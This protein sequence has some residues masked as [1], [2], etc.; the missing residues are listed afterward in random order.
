MSDLL[1]YYNDLILM[2]APGTIFI[3]EGDNDIAVDKRPSEI[4]QT[5]RELT[6][7]IM[8]DLPGARVIF[9]SPKPSIARCDL[10]PMYRRLNRRLAR[11]CESQPNL[12]F[13]DV[14]EV[15]LDKDGVV[16]QDIFLEDGLHMNNKG[17]DLWAAILRE[18][19]E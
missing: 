9:I 18:Y 6:A 2:R 4:L 8:N 11:Y 5:A 15:M 7:R 12:E 13:A 1:Y 14:W 10:A 19:L 17:Y 3:Y 16:L